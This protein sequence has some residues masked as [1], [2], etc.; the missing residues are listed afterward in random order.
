ML[1]AGEWLLRLFW[2][3]CEARRACACARAR[4]ARRARCRGAGAHADLYY[5]IVGGLGG[6]PKYQ[7]QF[8]KDV[9]QLAAVARRTTGDD[10]VTVLQGEAAT[11]AAVVKAFD[12]LRTR[13]KPTD[14]V[15][16]DARRPRQLRRRAYKLN[17]P[18]PD[19]DG[20][21]LLKLLAAVPARS[22]LVVNTTSASGAMLETWAGDGRTLITATRSGFE[23]NATRFAEL[24]GDGARRRL[25]R[26]Q[27]E[28][29]DH[30]AGS[31]RLRVA[32]GGRQLHEAGHARDRASADR[33]ATARRASPSR[34]SRRRRGAVDAGGRG[35]RSAERERSTARSRRCASAREQWRPTRISN[36]L[37]TLLVQLADVQGKIDAAQRKPPSDA[38]APGSRRGAASRAARAS[39][40]CVDDRVRARPPAGA[41]RLRSAAYRGA[42]AEAQQLLRQAA[43]EEHGP[44]DQGRRGARERR[45]ARARTRSSRRRSRSI[46]RTR[47]CACAGASCSSRRIRTTRP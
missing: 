44:A 41:R 4:A 38:A 19:I 18:G 9:R 35:A 45:R 10:R 17:L 24:F 23:R 40:L 27:Q 22:Q 30:G 25:G 15:A 3:R 6:E 36:E 1:K 26:H 31:V 29:R 7:E 34:G 14:S 20:A 39:V 21:E 46:R 28:R 42:R 16:V 12:S 43:R 11:R 5:L 47:R 33:R 32:R 8:D 13:T 37:Q 2:G